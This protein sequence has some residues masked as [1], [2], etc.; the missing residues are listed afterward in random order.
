[1]NSLNNYFIEAGPIAN[2]Q[3][4][5][6]GPVSAVTVPDAGKLVGVSFTTAGVA[7][8][9]LTTFDV[10]KVSGGTEADSGIDAT[11]AVTAARTGGMMTMD[12]DVQLAQ[13][14]SF[15]IQS[16]AQCTNNNTTIYVS[17][18]INR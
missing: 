13:G 4:A 6:S 16:N 18:I 1:M 11:M 10:M 7:V 12:G 3:T 15:Y 14:D 5:D 17:Y 9:V 8:D 2:V